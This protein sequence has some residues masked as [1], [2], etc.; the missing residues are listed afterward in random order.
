MAEGRVVVR[1]SADDHVLFRVFQAHYPH[2]PGGVQPYTEHHHAELEISS[3]LSGSGVY[4]CSGV[5]YPFR[6]GDVFMHCGNDAHCFERIGQGTPLSLVVIQFEPRFIWMPGGEW[7]DSKYLQLFMENST[8]SRHIS[9]DAPVA[10]TICGLLQESF[11]ECHDQNPAYDM[12]VKAKL[13]TILANLARYF[14]NDLSCDVSPINIR[15][16]K[17]MEHSINY[18]LSHLD[19]SL[20][21]DL[22]AKEARMSRSYYSTMFKSLNGV[23]VWNYITSQ[24][25]DKAQR[26]LES[27]VLS[28][29]Q[30]SESCGFNNIANFNRAFKKTTGRTP[31]VYRKALQPPFQAEEET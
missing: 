10:Q 21:L 29:T 18:I 16:L 9:H 8:I 4:S 28:V 11:Q 2:T 1:S 15:H 24:R 14:H 30:I 5:D 25:I 7:F 27:T 13:L 12:L 3:I 23:S 26:L 17:H 31:R 20:T 6:A 19:E 22:L